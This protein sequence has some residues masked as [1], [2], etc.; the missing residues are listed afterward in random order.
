MFD[1][2]FL[3]DAHNDSNEVRVVL[4][5]DVARRLAWY[6][7]LFNMLVLFIA[8]KEKSV[9]RVRRRATLDLWDRVWTICGSGPLCPAPGATSRA[10]RQWLY[11]GTRA[12]V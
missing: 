5:L 9:K 12:N 4:W 3:H 2:T 10:A 11:Q 8:H 1:D 7:H 6:L